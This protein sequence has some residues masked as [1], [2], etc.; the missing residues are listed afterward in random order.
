MEWP[1]GIE[2]ALGDDLE[3]AVR[4]TKHA[5][6]SIGIRK[7]T[8]ETRTR[9]V[10]LIVGFTAVSKAPRLDL[11]LGDFHIQPAQRSIMMVRNLRVRMDD[12][13]VKELTREAERLVEESTRREPPEE[14]EQD[15]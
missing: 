1:G 11:L 2:A 13:R 15:A 3:R 6:V 9:R 5:V 8:D 12:E 7:A 14:F 10:I 4:N